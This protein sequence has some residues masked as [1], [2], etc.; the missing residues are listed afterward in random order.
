MRRAAAGFV[1]P[2]GSICAFRRAKRRAAL[3]I[4]YT[5]G[6]RERRIFFAWCFKHVNSRNVSLTLF[7][8]ERG[9]ETRR[10]K[11]EGRAQERPLG[12]CRDSTR[13]VRRRPAKFQRAV[14]FGG[15]V[16]ALVSAAKRMALE[17]EN[18][19]RKNV[20][21]RWAARSEGLKIGGIKEVTYQRLPRS[22]R[23]PR[24][25]PRPPPPRPPRSPPRPPPPPPP[26]P[27]RPPPPPER[28]VCGR[29]SL[30]TRFR[31]PKF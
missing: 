23:S 4:S 21:F 31:P 12:I 16:L 29:A 18:C 14:N 2:G 5:P 1:S 10:L 3:F 28:S 25:P 27:P 6:S 24:S 19:H 30:T 15:E 20:R 17:R 7:G 13:K 11:Q 26:Y 8:S 9:G 22:P